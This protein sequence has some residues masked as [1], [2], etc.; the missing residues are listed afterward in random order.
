ML[1][2]IGR[3]QDLKQRRCGCPAGVPAG[4]GGSDSSAAS[5]SSGDSEMKTTFF[6]MRL[7]GSQVAF[8]PIS[9]RLFKAAHSFDINVSRLRFSKAAFSSELK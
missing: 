6:E 7:P 1:A 9:L 4:H 8:L 2:P 3:C 5:Q